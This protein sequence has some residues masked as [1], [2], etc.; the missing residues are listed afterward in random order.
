MQVM[1]TIFIVRGEGP[2]GKRLSLVIFVVF[3]MIVMF[4]NNPLSAE[5]EPLSP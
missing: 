2:P 1:N 3:V 4:V 5:E